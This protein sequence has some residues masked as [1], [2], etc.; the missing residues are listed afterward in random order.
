MWQKYLFTKNTSQ[1]KLVF[2][3]QLTGL[4]VSDTK[5]WHEYYCLAKWQPMR[6]F[7]LQSDTKKQHE[8]SNH[9]NRRKEIRLPYSILPNNIPEEP[10][11]F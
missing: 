11:L 6:K 5:A 1:L 7:G 3:F 10:N 9:H 4:D 2:K 8:L